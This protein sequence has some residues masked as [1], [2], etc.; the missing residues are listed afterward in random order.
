MHVVG[1]V[2]VTHQEEQNHLQD[3][4]PPEHQRSHG[5]PSNSSNS[6]DSNLDEV[7]LDDNGNNGPNQDVEETQEDGEEDD[8]GSSGEFTRTGS[9]RRRS[10]GGRN[11]VKP[12]SNMD[13]SATDEDSQACDGG[14]EGARGRG[15]DGG[16]NINTAGVEI[17]SNSNLRKARYA[18]AEQCLNGDSGPAGDVFGDQCR[19]RHRVPMECFGSNRL[20]VVNR[21]SGGIDGVLRQG[22]QERLHLKWHIQQPVSPRDWIALCSLNESDPSKWLA[23][24]SEGSVG[25]GPTGETMWLLDLSQPALTHQECGKLMCFR[26]YSGLSLSCLAQSEPLTLQP[27]S[28]K[29]ESC[30]GSTLPRSSPVISFKKKGEAPQS[31]VKRRELPASDLARVRANNSSESDSEAETSAKYRKQRG[32]RLLKKK[33]ALVQANGYPPHLNGGEEESDNSDT[34]L[35]PGRELHTWNSHECAQRT[36]DVK[37]HV[38]LNDN[39][40]YYPIWTKSPLPSR[41]RALEDR[42]NEEFRSI[43]ETLYPTSDPPPPPLP[44]RAFPPSSSGGARNPK[45]RPLE[46]TRA[47]PYQGGCIAMTPPEVLRQHKPVSVLS[48]ASDNRKECAGGSD[49]KVKYRHLQNQQGPSLPP[50][51]R[52]LLNPEDSFAFEIIDTDELRPTQPVNIAVMSF[53]S[54][55]TQKPQAVSCTRL[56]ETGRCES[57]GFNVDNTVPM[58]VN[59]TETQSKTLDGGASLSAATSRSV[60]RRTGVDGEA[61]ANEESRPSDASRTISSHPKRPMMLPVNEV[62]RKD[63]PCSGEDNVNGA[64]GF[65]VVSA[66]LATPEQDSSLVDSSS[67]ENLLDDEDDAVFLTP[68][69]EG[70]LGQPYTLAESSSEVQQDAT[71]GQQS[72]KYQS[73]I[74]S[75]PVSD[76]CSGNQSSVDVSSSQGAGQGVSTVGRSS[77]GKLELPLPGSTRPKNFPTGGANSGTFQDRVCEMPVI[78]T[79]MPDSSSQMGAASAVPDSNLSNTDSSSLLSVPNPSSS[80]ISP[81]SPNS[82]SDS[83][84]A[85]STATE[86]STS[87]GSD[88][89]TMVL[90]NRSSSTDSMGALA[91]ANLDIPSSEALENC[92][93]PL[94]TQSPSDEAAS[95]LDIVDLDEENF[96]QNGADDSAEFVD[97]SSEEPAAAK[98]PSLRAHRPLSRQVSHPPI[99]A[100]GQSPAHYCTTSRIPLQRQIGSDGSATTPRPRNRLLSRV[101][102]VTSPTG[103][104]QCPPTPTHH[105]R[106]ANRPALPVPLSAAEQD[107]ELQ[108]YAEQDQQVPDAA[109]LGVGNAYG[110]YPDS[111]QETSMC[112]DSS[113]NQAHTRVGENCS[114]LPLRHLSTTRLPSIPERSAKSQRLELPAEEEPLPPYWEARIDSHGRIFYI[115]HVNRTTTWQRPTSSSVTRARPISNELQRQQLDRRYQS[116]RR[117]IT[118]RRLDSEDGVLGSGEGAHGQSHAASSDG[119]GSSSG[120]EQRSQQHSEIMLHMPAVRFISRPDFFSILHMNQEA[121][122]LYNRN[123]SLKHMVS[124]IR[125]DPQAFERYQ[126]NRDLVTLVNLF[127][128][129]LRDLPRG[130]ETKFDRNGKAPVPPPR[131]A[132]NCGCSPSMGTGLGGAAVPRVLAPPDIPTAYNEKVVAFLRQPNI[133]DILKER[134]AMVGTS[135]GLRDKINAVRVDGTLALDRLSDDID[136]TILLS[137]FEQEIMSYVPVVPATAR[138]PRGSPQLSPQASPGLSRA[139]ARAPAPYRRDFEAKLRNFYRKL[140]SKG[141][142]QGPGKLK[143]HIRR[144]HLLEDAFNKIMAASKKDLQKCKLYVT[145]D[146][147]EGL[148]YGGPS[149]EFFFLLSRELFNPYYGLFEYSANDTYTVQVSPMS[150]FVDNHHEWFRFSGRVLGLALVHQYLL[151]AFFTRPF[152]KALLRLPVSLSDLES[153]DGEFHQSLLWIKENDISSDLLDL[154]FAVTEEVFGQVVERELKPGGRNINVTEKNKKEYLERVVRWRLERGVAEQTESLVRGFYEVVDPR[155][156]SVFDARELELVIAGTAEIDLSDWRKNTEYR[157]GYHD[158]H[159]VM[160]WFWTA[161]E[162]FSNEQRLRLLQFVTGT[163]SI[164][165]EGFAALRGSTGP[166]KF[167]V[168]KWGKPNSLPR[169]HTC[170]NRLDL[171]PYP[172]PEILYEKLLLAVEET[173]TFGIE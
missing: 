167:C 160:Q 166:R 34:A 18:V 44:P 29:P 88:T 54:Q 43:Y 142:G 24:L 41:S 170:F 130:W 144:E 12:L 57:H 62:S 124:K 145:F 152:Y 136:L 95:G 3:P 90:S 86:C 117:T 15:S 60:V 35:V 33:A 126:H 122:S 111:S 114:I 79:D 94:G 25:A 119:S 31:A 137:L 159:P 11:L 102:A 165:Y 9:R 141:Y 68:D 110:I 17:C 71:A 171:P 16:G 158:N 59:E 140:E 32:A 150:A 26:Y 78:L 172:T 39:V 52:K 2:A 1:G 154:T 5:R 98:S 109:A 84:M 118:S 30:S 69:N 19:T 157:S 127:A 106:A 10:V 155:L 4:P 107:Q 75:W 163:S 138:S 49:G 73:V 108:L 125:R 13:K 128:D 173:N 91:S 72:N 93:K 22:H 36:L 55:N 37:D 116:I 48:C 14:D 156:V 164:P 161:I 134:H 20:S 120:G 65:P 45:H 131:P 133:L 42:G 76:A 70:V 146:R 83:G 101:A 85:L 113:T 40:D 104:P 66:P 81:V 96:G 46:R 67:V 153:L 7:Q 132:V 135:Q 28:S 162:R 99:T 129:S 143:L 77:E 112:E 51:P 74:P 82:L 53:S 103:I 100:L 38:A 92:S 47:L 115:D 87:S 21:G 8:T 50:K 169:A 151:D 121:L 23:C 105:A 168:E 123:G 97:A 6:D 61:S 89:N 149:R 148:D 63:P 56:K 64:D 139:N 27:D 58:K 147:E 80:S